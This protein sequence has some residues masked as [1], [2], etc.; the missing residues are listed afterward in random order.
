MMTCKRAV[1][2]LSSGQLPQASL[3][4]RAHL[5]AHLLFCPLCN[6]FAKNDKILTQVI[7]G[8]KHHQ[9]KKTDPPAE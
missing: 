8:Y 1:F 7:T 4:M 6:S 2:L 5:R 3:W 9:L